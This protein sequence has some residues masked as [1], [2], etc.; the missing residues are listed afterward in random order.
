LLAKDGNGFTL[1]HN[2]YHREYYKLPQWERPD[3]DNAPVEPETSETYKINATFDETTWSSSDDDGTLVGYD[4]SGSVV[5]CK[6]RL[7]GNLVA[8]NQMVIPGS[9]KLKLLAKLLDQR[10]DQGHIFCTNYPVKKLFMTTTLMT[11]TIHT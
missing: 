9:R 2:S 8:D 4:S 11:T 10:E 3:A 5:F 7:S 6:H 1:F